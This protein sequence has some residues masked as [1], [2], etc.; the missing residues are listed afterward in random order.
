[1]ILWVI[2]LYSTDKIINFIS[3]NKISFIFFLFFSNI[4]YSQIAFE[5][6]ASYIGVDYSYG[7]SEYGGGVSFAD[8]NND[9]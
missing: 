8:F 1:M 6:V 5:D 4:L 9:G 2:D 3:M 7:D